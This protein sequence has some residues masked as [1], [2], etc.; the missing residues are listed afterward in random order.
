MAETV[1]VGSLR[2]GEGSLHR[3]LQAIGLVALG[4]LVERFKSAAL[5]TAGDLHAQCDGAK[6]A[7]VATR[8]GS[9]TPGRP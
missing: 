3:Q 1:R 8:A 4:R 9:P 5:A 6:S 7:M 2:E